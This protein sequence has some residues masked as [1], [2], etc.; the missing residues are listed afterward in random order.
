MVSIFLN[1][2]NGKGFMKP[3]SDCKDHSATDNG[4]DNLNL[5]PKPGVLRSLLRVR[6]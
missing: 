1:I 2:G 5:S 3:L 6:E 4:W